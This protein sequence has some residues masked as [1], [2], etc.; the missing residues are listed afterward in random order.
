MVL[1]IFDKSFGGLVGCLQVWWGV[2]RFG[3]VFGGF[4]ECLGLI[5]EVG[6]CFFGVGSW[7]MGGVGRLFDVGFFW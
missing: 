3:G 1:R 6:E 4:V 5:G 7:F 2:C